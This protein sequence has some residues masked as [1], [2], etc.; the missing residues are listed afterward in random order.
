[1]AFGG[2]L[3]A[4]ALAQTNAPGDS[5]YLLVFETSTA[6]KR[7]SENVQRTVGDLLASGMNGQLRAGDTIGVW[8]FNETLSAGS[9]PLVRW[10]PDRRLAIAGKVTEFLRA[11]KFERTARLEVVLPEVNR[12][13]TN[14]TRLTVVLFTEGV[15]PF[16]GTPF[17]AEI[18]AAYEPFRENQKAE[19]MPFV[20]VLRSVDGRYHGYA[21]TPAP[22]AVEFPQFPPE[23]VVVVPPAAKV[24]PKVDPPKPTVPPL[25]VI[26]KKSEETS[27]AVVLPQPGAEPPSLPLQKPK[28]DA[29]KLF[30]KLAAEQGL[31]QETNPPTPPPGMP[32]RSPATN[33]PL[34]VVSPGPAIP[35]PVPPARTNVSAS[36]PDIP[37]ATTRT[38]SNA[39]SPAASQ[40]PP[41]VQAV[42]TPPAAVGGK[43]WL[44]VA[45]GGVLVI[46]L[47]VGY[48]LARRQNRAHVSLITRSMDRDGRK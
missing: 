22:W 18:K 19:R 42:V 20:T 35:S 30:E 28:T 32:V 8:T 17:D 37:P 5:R 29:E 3:T 44:V 46:G 16:V 7:R 23:P 36:E 39:I 21:V 4:S 13:V 9:L 26:G 24:E 12:L 48:L 15:G 14:S 10:A 27:P 31:L 2:W 25:I 34:A 11:Q 45:G 6:M 38:S 33:P 43:L 40:S 1:V 41:A 47:G